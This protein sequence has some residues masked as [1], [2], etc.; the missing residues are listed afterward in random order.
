MRIK[1][2]HRHTTMTETTCPN[3][4]TLRACKKEARPAEVV[5]LASVFEKSVTELKLKQKLLK[6]KS[7]IKKRYSA[8]EL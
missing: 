5:A 3:R 7:T 8:L 2:S 6:Y 1:H 4:I